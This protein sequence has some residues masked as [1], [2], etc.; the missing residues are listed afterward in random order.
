LFLLGKK[1]KKNGLCRGRRDLGGR[2]KR[3]GKRRT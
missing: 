3:E 1:K 2:R